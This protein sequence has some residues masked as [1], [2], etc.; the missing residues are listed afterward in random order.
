MGNGRKDFDHA[1]GTCYGVGVGP[2]DAELM[3]LKAARV[4]GACAVVAAP[5]TRGGATLAL[6]IAAQAVDLSGKE[7]VRLPFAMSRDVGERARMHRA[8][9]EIVVG[10]LAQGKDIAFLTL[11][12]PGV[13]SSFY[14]LADDLRKRGFG[15]EVVPGVT[16]FSAVSAC[17]GEGLTEMDEPLHVV[18]A[19]AWAA[20]IDDVLDLPGTKVLMKPCGKLPEIIAALDRHGDLPRAALISDCGLPT[21]YVCHDLATFDPTEHPSYFT[22]VVV[23]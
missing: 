1:P 10:R 7:I 6:D 4:I 18:P 12:D 22:T 15:V 19:A 5:V 2:G 13:F 21:E 8:A 20:R 23:K 16:S 3:T 14:Y 11:G 9:A 17:L